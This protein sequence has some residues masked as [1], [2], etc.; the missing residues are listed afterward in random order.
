MEEG[1]RLNKYL[2]DAGYCSRRQADRLIGEG[3]VSVDGIK[4]VM[5]QRI[6]R[7]SKILVDGKPVKRTAAPVLLAVNKPVGVITT[8]EKAEPANIVTYVG[9]PERIYPIG[10]LDKDSEGLILMTNQG[11]LANRIAHARGLHEKEY[12][13]SVNRPVTREF[14][15]KMAAGVKIGENLT[16][17]PCRCEKISRTRFRIVL[18]QG[19]NRQIRRMCEALGYKVLELRRVR[20]MNITLGDLRLGEYRV[21]AGDEYDE[22]LRELGMELT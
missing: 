2:S 20:I 16:T 10:R 14:T 7:E 12:I 15:E 9:Y 13:V 18:T 5:G 4:A 22:L 17:R 11:E 3:R 1:I 21:I 19:L 8:S 6:S